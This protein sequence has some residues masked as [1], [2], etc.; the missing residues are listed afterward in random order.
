MNAGSQDASQPIQGTV[1]TLRAMVKKHQIKEKV[2]KNQLR[3]ETSEYRE[4]K[5]ELYPLD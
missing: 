2:Q 3:Q 4:K 5:K 1:Y